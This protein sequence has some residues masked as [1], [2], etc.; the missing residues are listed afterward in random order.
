VKL[1]DATIQPSA[2]PVCVDSTATSV[3]PSLGAVLLSIRINTANVLDTLVLRGVA[4][5]LVPTN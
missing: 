2:A 4:L 3:D 5:H 1:D